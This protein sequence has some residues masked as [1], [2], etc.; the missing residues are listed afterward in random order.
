MWERVRPAFSQVSGQAGVSPDY[1]LTD[2]RR[3]LLGRAAGGDDQYLPSC[4][5]IAWC[6]VGY[7][8]PIVNGQLPKSEVGHAFTSL[9][10]R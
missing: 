5:T 2:V 9:D 3:A 6:K 4:A 7:L 10:C 8:K 1:P